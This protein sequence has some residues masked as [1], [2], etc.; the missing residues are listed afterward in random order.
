[1]K[2]RDL[3]KH[4]RGHG[5]EKRREGGNHTI[6]RNPANNATAP[7]P[8]QNEVADVLARRICRELGIPPA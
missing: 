3:G 8:R 4:M 7:V 1:M 6:W 2:R 5:C